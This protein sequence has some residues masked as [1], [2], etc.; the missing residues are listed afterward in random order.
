MFS[1]FK[2]FDVIA[3]FPKKLLLAQLRLQVLHQKPLA[4]FVIQSV[5]V[6]VD[7]HLA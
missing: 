2:K 3:F 5:A 6:R 4:E 1:N 7:R